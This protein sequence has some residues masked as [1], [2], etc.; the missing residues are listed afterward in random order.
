[1]LNNVKTTLHIKTFCKII[2]IKLIMKY[3]ITGYSSKFVLQ[4]LQSGYHISCNSFCFIW[5]NK[6]NVVILFRV[7]GHYTIMELLELRGIFVRFINAK[8]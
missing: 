5:K 2:R 7:Q 1:M 3:Y 8:N 4:V 6:K